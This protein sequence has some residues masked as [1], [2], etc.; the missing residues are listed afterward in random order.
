[1]GGIGISLMGAMAKGAIQGQ[2]EK[3]AVI[4]AVF[5]ATM[6]VPALILPCPDQTGNGWPVD[7]IMEIGSVPCPVA[8]PTGK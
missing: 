2:S 7:R 6:P 3:R 1:M 4:G 5:R 8:S